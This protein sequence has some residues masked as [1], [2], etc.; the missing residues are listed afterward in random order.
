MEVV[1]M[2]QE[3]FVQ[4]VRSGKTVLVDFWAPWC[5]PCRMLGPT[6]EKLAERYEGRLVVGK[7]N[8][9]DNMGAASAMRVSS[10]PAVY[11]FKD[12]KPVDL[13]VGLVP[14]EVLD[15]KIK[16]LL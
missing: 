11:F 9:D 15:E 1:N 7:C 13:S 16:A 12:G 8:V 5:Q 2:N 4:A 10:I 3:Q 6:I 14:E